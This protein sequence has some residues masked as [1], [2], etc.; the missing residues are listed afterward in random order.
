VLGF[1][2]AASLVHPASGYM[3]GSLLRRA[4][5]VAA[6]VAAQLR[7]DPEAG[8]AQLARAGW[9]ALWPPELRRKHALYQFGLEKLMR[10][11]EPQLRAHFATF[12]AMPAEQWFGF[13]ANTASVPELL[14][15][16]LRLFATA[17]WSVKAGLMGMQGREAGLGLRLLRPVG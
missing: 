1:G 17:P 4:P 14:A 7:S 9:Q 12:F 15:A 13:L 16:M 5:A 11:A 3:V 2:G 8:S 6:A 10:F